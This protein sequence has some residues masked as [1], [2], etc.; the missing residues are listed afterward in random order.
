MCCDCA[1]INMYQV[2]SLTLIKCSISF[3]SDFEIIEEEVKIL[4]AIILKV[5]GSH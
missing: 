1:K 3:L 2:K 4:T 5:I